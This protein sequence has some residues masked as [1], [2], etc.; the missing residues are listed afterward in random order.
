MVFKNGEPSEKIQGADP[1]KLQR[2]VSELAS[3]ATASGTSSSGGPSGSWRKG[4]LPKGYGD[5]TD[6]VD[7]KGLELLNSDTEFGTIRELFDVSKP[8]AL[9]TGKASS[10]KKDWVESDT[11]EQL[12]MFMPFQSMLK[13]HTMQ[14]WG[15]LMSWML[16]LV[17]NIL[18]SDHVL[19]TRFNRR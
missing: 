10:K 18:D 17:V 15:V 5:V 9:T 4:D 19:S 3:F 2:V 8:S 7:V 11:D 16:V 6:Q 13:V 1:A 14:V 12:M